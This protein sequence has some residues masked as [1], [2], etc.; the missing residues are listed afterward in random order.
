MIKNATP[1][2]ASHAIGLP[3]GTSAIG[4]DAPT[5]G[6]T[7]WNTTSS[8]FE[9]YTGS[10]WQAVA[11]EGNVTIAEDRFSGNVTLGNV[12][13]GPMTYSYNAGQ[14][15]QALVFVS[16]V[17]QDPASAY[18]FQG[19]TTIHFT[20]APGTGINNILILHNFASTIAA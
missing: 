13:F 19:N 2:T 17:Y 3:I 6:Q 7:R 8:R 14:E 4:P 1:R 20:S 11:H 5:V 16:G 12:N 9:Y 18:S 10:V 15:K